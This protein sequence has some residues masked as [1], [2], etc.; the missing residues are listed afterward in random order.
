MEDV[1]HEMLE[2]SRGIGE[3]K[4]HHHPFKRAIACLKGSFPFITIGDLD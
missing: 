1:I 2:G 4:W 3:A